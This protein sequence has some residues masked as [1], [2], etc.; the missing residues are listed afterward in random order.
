MEQEKIAK[1]SILVGRPLQGSHPDKL[2]GI[3]NPEE[4]LDRGW[5]WYTWTDWHL[6]RESGSSLKVIT[7]RTKP[8]GRKVRPITGVMNTVLGKEEMAVRL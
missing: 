7:V 4:N 2:C 6:I 8:W 1:A 5:W 3:Q